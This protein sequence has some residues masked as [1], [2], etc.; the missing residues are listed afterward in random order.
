MVEVRQLVLVM[1]LVTGQGTPG[2]QDFPRPVEIFGLLVIVEMLGIGQMGLRG[3]IG[4]RLVQGETLRM[5]V[6]LAELVRETGQVTGVQ[7]MGLEP[8]PWL[9]ES[10]ADP[11]PPEPSESHTGDGGE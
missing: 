1:S 5:M 9:G 10:R 11:P 3:R 7:R 2:R 8:R 6:R 4:H